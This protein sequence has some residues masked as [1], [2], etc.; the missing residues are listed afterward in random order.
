MKHYLNIEQTYLTA[1]IQGTKTFEI[2]AADRFYQAG[3]ILVF[4][5]NGY[6]DTPVNFAFEGLLGK[7]FLEK[8]QQR[9]ELAEDSPEDVH[10]FPVLSVFQSNEY[11]EKNTVVLS[12]G[13]EI[14]E[15]IHMDDCSIMPTY[16]IQCS[17]CGIVQM[18]VLTSKS[19]LIH[20][21]FLC[22]R[23]KEEF[24]SEEI[25]DSFNFEEIQKDIEE[26]KKN[27]NI[28]DDKKN[29][30]S[31]C[32]VLENNS[33]FLKLKEFIFN[34]YSNNELEAKPFLRISNEIREI[35]NAK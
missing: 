28:I 9:M 8:E 32:E 34:M 18:G 13:K 19:S 14:K 1:I 20:K 15:V 2:R 21:P 27:L 22:E 16:K 23:C 33:K 7:S 3:D 31:D 4:H 26:L 35:L 5:K 24:N 11:L 6:W 12:L 29:V 10:E 25:K 17:S 30:I